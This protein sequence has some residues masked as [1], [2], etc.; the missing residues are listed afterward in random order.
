MANSISLNCER[1]TFIW[2]M[3]GGGCNSIT[4]FLLL[5]FVT[6]ILGSN[7]GGIFS[8]SFATAQ[9]MLTIGKF[10]VRAYQA[11]DV[12][13]EIPYTD[14]L[15]SRM[16]TGFLMM[17]FSGIYVLVNGY[18]GEKSYI[19]LCVCF[20]KLADAIEDV[21]HGELQ[22]IG[23][24]DVAGKLLTV[25]NMATIVVF[26]VSLILTKHLFYTCLITAMISIVFCFCINIYFTQKYGKIKWEADKHKIL[27]LFLDCLPLFIGAFLSL[28]IYNSP[29]NAIDQYLSYEYQ[30]YYSILFMPA[31]VINLF[32]EF[33][34]KPLL[35][36]LALLWEK[37]EISS[38]LNL[39]FRLLGLVLGLTILAMMGAYFI[40]IPVLSFIYGIEL[41]TYRVEL[42]VLM[43]GGGFGAAV[44]LLNNV[45]TS[46]RK[47]NAILAGYVL[48]AMV[49]S[50]I[51]PI[52]VEKLNIYG[53]SL[54]YLISIAGLFIFFFIV[55][56]T[57]SFLKM[58]RAVK[59]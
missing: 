14:Y 43:C 12:Q 40:G 27:Q 29:K 59:K 30:T 10:G 54:S 48:I 47:Q 44:Y 51:S 34:F 31:F 38:F 15:I 28:Y 24:L 45:L 35:T 56:I 26:G 4:S 16:I 42:L 57:N 1:N 55:F 21:F 6:R 18:T 13:M 46:M 9:L 50:M 37:V 23:R 49:I 32:S 41:Q 20:I 11:T 3:I 36:N 19:I 5:L 7:D 25:R 58:R 33:V 52:L 17:F 53:A 2:N 22:R 39:V 8:F